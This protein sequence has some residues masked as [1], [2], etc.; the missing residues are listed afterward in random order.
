[1]LPFT[2]IDFFLFAVLYVFIIWLFVLL[3]KFKNYKIIIFT[4]SLIYLIFYYKYTIAALSF[5]ITT[6]LFTQFLS[7]KINH[8]LI[9]SIIIALPMILIKVHYNP[10][11]IYFAGLSFV[12][13]RAIQVN[14]DHS[15]EETLNFVNY[16]NFLFFIP[17][18]YIGPL[19]KYKRFVLN[20]EKCV[21][22]SEII[23]GGLQEIIKGILYKFI[24]AESILR[25]WLNS[26]QDG[27][28]SLQHINDIY[29]Y[30]FYL[31]FD[32][33][34]YSSMAIGMA[35]LVGINLPVNF[36]KPFLA[37][38]PPDFWQRWHAS[39]TNWL[40]DYLFKPLY[41]WLNTIKKLKKQSATKQN[42]AIFFTLF[43]MGIWNG[44]E[45]N[46]LWSGIIYGIYSVTHNIYT[47]QCRKK[48]KDVFFGKLNPTFV[49]YISVFIT[50]NLVCLALYIFSGR[51]Q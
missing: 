13:F 21:I 9:S 36:N 3:L 5:G 44:F 30:T 31:F 20:C 39:L 41:K 48:D 43:V 34:G 25:F 2:D 32:F 47:I 27:L 17:S 33:A 35:K 4:L 8:R 45:S 46:F 40:S 49:K 18:L 29:A 23:L 16:F 24:I 37:I 10:D 50:F 19:D 51:Y 11:F 12:T 6:F 28:T 15:K 26:E 22:N 1:M 14:I 7:L 38:N 42:I